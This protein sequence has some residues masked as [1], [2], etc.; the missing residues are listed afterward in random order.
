MDAANPDMIEDDTSRAAVYRMMTT[1][2]TA[3]VALEKNGNV[4]ACLMADKRASART[5]L[6]TILLHENNDFSA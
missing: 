2:T 3:A 1:T 4:D 5:L 6:S